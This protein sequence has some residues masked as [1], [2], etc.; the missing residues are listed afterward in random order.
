MKGCIPNC[1]LLGLNRLL[2]KILRLVAFDF[3]FYIF[4]HISSNFTIFYTFAQ[5]IIKSNTIRSLLFFK[6]NYYSVR[7]TFSEEY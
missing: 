4:L 3:W 1:E 5:K 7:S 6:K 2:T